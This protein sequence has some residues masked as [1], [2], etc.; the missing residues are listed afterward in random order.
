MAIN[1][2]QKIKTA[3]HLFGLWAGKPIKDTYGNKAVINFNKRP[4]FAEL[5]ALEIYKTHNY[6]GVWVDTYRKCFRIG[7]PE[8]YEPITLPTDINRKFEKILLENGGPKG[9]WDLLLWKNQELKFVE[10]KRKKKDKI[11]QNQIQFLNS[12]LKVGYDIEDFEIFEWD[13]KKSK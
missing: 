13:I 12:A 10:L 2:T 6:Y 4:L 9:A 1:N 5:A 3:F 7:L 11:R 8:E